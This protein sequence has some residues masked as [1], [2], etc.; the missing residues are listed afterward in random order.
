[1]TDTDLIALSEAY[2]RALDARDVEALV[3]V[4]DPGCVLTIETHGIQYDGADAIRTLFS[5]RWEGPMLA[6]HHDFT[7]TPS[8]AAG[9]IA[10]QFTVTYS[11]DGAP[12]PKSN[13][14]VFTVR[15][16][17]ITCI[18]VYMAGANS[19]RT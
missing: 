19:I 8:A 1:M 5:T 9:R 4:L 13:A 6:R 7:H 18:Q 3:A 11:G 16:G 10:S 17:M 12:D 14:N 2:F 15:D